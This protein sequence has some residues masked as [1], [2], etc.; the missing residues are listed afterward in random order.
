MEP[1]TKLDGELVDRW[2]KNTRQRPFQSGK[3]QGGKRKLSHKQIVA[4]RK[5][6]RRNKKKGRKQ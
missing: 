5:V 1:K 2:S 6:E 3:H 4:R